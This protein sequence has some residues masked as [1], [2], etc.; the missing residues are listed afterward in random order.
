MAQIVKKG[1][2]FVD[3]FYKPELT[4]SYELHRDLKSCITLA[5]AQEIL[6]ER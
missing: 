1:K 4:K 2:L 3:I 6:S 5:E